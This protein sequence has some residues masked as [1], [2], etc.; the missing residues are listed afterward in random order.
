MTARSATWNSGRLASIRATVSP[1]PTP[2]SCSPRASASTRSRS[3][4]HVSDTSS[5][6]VRTATRSGWSSAVIRKASAMVAAPTARD[7]ASAADA[8]AMAGTYRARLTHVEALAGEASYVVREADH[9]QCHHQREA[10]EPR[11]LHR[12][13]RDRA[14]ADL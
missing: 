7:D 11:A 13:E 14:P 12:R 2:S 8:V 10:D 6:F 4:A 1:R 5:S 3:A 9:E